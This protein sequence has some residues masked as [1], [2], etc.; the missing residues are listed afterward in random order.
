MDAQKYIEMIHDKYFFDYKKMEHKYSK[1]LV[2]E[3]IQLLYAGDAKELPLTDTGSK[4]LLYINSKI[5]D[6]AAAMKSLISYSGQASYSLAAVENEIVSTLSIEQIETNRESVRNILSGLAPRN[7]AEHRIAGMKKGFEFISDKNNTITAESVRYLYEIM[8]NPFLDDANDRLAEN[9]L[10]RSGPVHIYNQTRNQNVHDGMAHTKL[11]YH[12]DELF[13]FIQRTDS[14]NDLHKAAAI[15]Y[16]V[17]YLH[18][19]FDGNGRMARMMHLWYLLQHGYSASLFLPFSSIIQQTKNS[20]Y[21]AFDFT[22]NNAAV[23]GRLDITP[24]LSYFADE[25]Y[26]KIGNHNLQNDVLDKFQMLLSKGSVTEKE[27]ELFHFVLSKYGTAEFS[28][29]ELEKDFRNCAYATIRSFVLKMTAE[30]ILE[31]H[32]YGNRNKYCLIS[33]ESAV[34]L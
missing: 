29:K 18:P 6:T 4:P 7:E 34:E 27:K 17:A 32:S 12:M 13:A 15:H 3:M 22:E 25:V 10:Y 16:Y 8:V 11:P 33:A 23:S 5:A 28:T 24:F 21:K 31:Q 19:Y 2:K 30:G 26:S 9:Q 1:A 14:M 20:Y